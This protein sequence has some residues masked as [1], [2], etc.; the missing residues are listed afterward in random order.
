[1]SIKKHPMANDE[2]KQ[3]DMTFIYSGKLMPELTDTEVSF[4]AM[5]NPL[6]NQ[7]VYWWSYSNGLFT[8]ESK[9]DIKKTVQSIRTNEKVSLDTFDIFK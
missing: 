4:S 9:K 2:N 1:M 3:Y 6:N 8:A 5:I 7:W